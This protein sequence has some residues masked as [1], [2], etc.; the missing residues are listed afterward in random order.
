MVQ[1]QIRYLDQ[2]AASDAGR[3][4]KAVLIER[5]EL[6]PGLT[7][8][9][10]G[11]GPGTDLRGMAAAVGESGSVIGV[12]HDEAMI[13][14]AACRVADD[15][16][17]E[18]RTGDAHALPV[19][20]ASVDRARTDR[21]LQH[22]TDPA[23]VL[24]Q[25]YRAVRPGGSITLAEPDW[26]T[27]II[28]DVDVETSR[29]YSRFVATQVVRN[30]AIGRQLARLATE[31]GFT[32]SAVDVKPIVFQDFSAAEQILK[33]A[34]VAERAVRAGAIAEQAAARWLDRLAQGPLLAAFNLFL[35]TAARPHNS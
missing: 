26:D 28:D 14:E 6:R 35:V 20:R 21:V 30:G 10:V 29:A 31:A 16:R 2:A 15:P 34:G 17:I 12:D 32:V 13:A 7:V 25:L 27:L 1:A 18:V 33:P 4:Y 5:L 3:D 22:V 23:K 8:L 11:C 19:E 9:D 24:A